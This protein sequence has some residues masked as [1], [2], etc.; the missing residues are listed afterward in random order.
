MYISTAIIAIFSSLVG[1]A[2]A[3]AGGTSSLPDHLPIF[4]PA[5][6][7][8]LSSTAANIDIYADE[9]DREWYENEFDRIE[10][11]DV[12]KA[13]LLLCKDVYATNPTWQGKN[14]GV[15]ERILGFS[16]TSR[17]LSICLLYSCRW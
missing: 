15:L 16:M 2:G 9:E 5:S 8:T 11:S 10:S 13:A 3:A 12:L 17:V 14:A 6:L 4:E 1:C 7:A